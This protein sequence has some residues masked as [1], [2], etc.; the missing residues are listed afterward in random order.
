MATLLD[1]SAEPTPLEVER[2]F[3]RRGLTELLDDTP[4]RTDA[5]VRAAPA[6]VALFLLSVLVMAPP[7][8]NP[9]LLVAAVG[10]GAVGWA[11]TNL[12]RGRTPF[13]GV[14]RIGWPERVAFVGGPV[15]VALADALLDGSGALFALAVAAATLA[16][17]VALLA[18]V[19]WLVNRGVVAVG[20]WLTREV[21]HT[22]ASTA[23]AFS[24][25]LPLVVVLITFALFTGEMWQTVG[26]LGPV[27]YLLL[28]LLFTGLSAAFLSSRRQLDL[29]ALATFED[30]GRLAAA[31]AHT[32]YAAAPP[33]PA[34]VTCP[35]DASQ[36]ANL[37]LV[38]TM[39]RLA[40][41][42]V[43][44]V[45]VFAF[46]LALGV[47]VVS[48]ETMQAWTGAPPE[49]LLS[50]SG[51]QRRYLVAWEQIRVAGF[52]AIFAGFY[53]AVASATDP[54]LRDAVQDTAEDAVREAC[55]ARVALLHH[56]GRTTR[57]PGPAGSAS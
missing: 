36:S 4:I 46:Y 28:F 3:L 1:V 17:Q 37:R 21:L 29:R 25:T 15:L 51:P 44:G 48:P 33:P 34:P 55:A 14:E 13:A 12:A 23:T 16:G 53:Y 57:S 42:G 52:L 18:A 7:S 20:V 54:T 30:P 24:R 43:V 39:S 26:R 9:L 22:F 8:G 50:W 49:V 32:P 35:L 41:A 10:L 27:P 40:V 2:W 5:S 31:L 38:A 6:L 11:G 45:A 56:V 47:V 19:L